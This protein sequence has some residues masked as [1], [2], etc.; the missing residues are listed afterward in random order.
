MINVVRSELVRLRRRGFL[1]GW[2]GL[3]AVMSALMNVVMFQFSTTD[4]PPPT[5]GPGVT[6]PTAAALADESGIVAGMGAVSA[7]LGVITLSFWAISVTTDYSTGLVRILVA[8][9]PRRWQ[10][11]VGKWLSLTLFT[12]AA[13]LVALIVT[14]MTAPIAARS[15]GFDPA[16]WGTNLPSVLWSATVDLFGALLVWGTIGLALST[17]TRSAGIAIGVGVGY[18][19]LLESVIK[20]AVSG[21]ADWLPGTTISAIASGGTANLSYGGAVALGAAY[22]VV[23][24]LVASVVFQRRDITD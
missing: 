12:A 9:H 15:A 4:A 19:L 14:V 13:T 8:A 21:I 5:N 3:T 18:V 7:I 23:A 11:I 2:F 22:I 17:V 20:A 24:F 6:F 1:L 16:S 10:L